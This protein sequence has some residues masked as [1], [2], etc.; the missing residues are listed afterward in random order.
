MYTY[1][2]TI[3]HYPKKRYR[4]ITPDGTCIDFG[5]PYEM[6]YTQHRDKYKQLNY[7][8]INSPFSDWTRKG[9]KTASFWEYWLCWHSENL[10]DA[11][12]NVMR[13]FN[14]KIDIIY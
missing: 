8:M 12:K 6:N 1:Y 2:L 7:I 9:I 13:I 14:I 3:S 11:L 10:G 4:I 5:N